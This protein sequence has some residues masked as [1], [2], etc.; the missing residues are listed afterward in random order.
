M[1]LT[2]P[3]VCADCFG[4]SGIRDFIQIN[5]VD[6]QCS[7]CD[8][9]PA[10]ASVALLDEVAEHIKTCLEYE[11][12]DAANHFAYE[13]REGGYIGETWVTWELLNEVVELELPKDDDN[14]L[15]EEIV[16]ILPDFAWCKARGYGL[17][18]QSRA[19]YSWEHFCEVVMHHRRFFFT[20]EG[21]SEGE[22]YL[23]G[24]VLDK[25]FEDA[26]KYSLF[27]CLPSGTRLFRA[28]F[29]KP[30]ARLTTAQDLG[31]PPKKLATQPNRMSPPGIP[32]FYACDNPETALRETANEKGR[33][34]VGSFESLRD[35]TILDLTNIP[36][37]PSLFQAIPDSLE[38]RPREVLGFLDHIVR[39]ISRPIQ[40]DDRVHINYIPTQVVTEFV[41]S[42]LT[43]GNSRIDGIKYPS[44][45][46][47]DFASYVMFATQENLL[48]LPEETRGQ[49]NDPW[50]KLTE[51][52]PN[53]VTQERIERWKAELL[54]R[55]RGDYQQ[56]LYGD[57]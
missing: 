42:K 9:E 20:N 4:D 54:E 57:E 49:N 8:G 16:S 51:T 46:H 21:E 3:F 27:R 19:R 45:I 10:D 40:R 47:P 6:A 31:P 25:L 55:Y 5:A 32:M 56:R 33:F 43:G 18:D 14:R 48:Q 29:L 52:T 41:R 36:L 15:L 13:T 2:C 17:D 30:G 35:A 53:Y 12:D 26:G 50:L 44:S 1:E 22:I 7:F 39:E 28:R 24:E 23:P 34:V 37:V 11:Y 38:F